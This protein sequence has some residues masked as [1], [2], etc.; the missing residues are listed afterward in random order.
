MTEI[1]A[2]GPPKAIGKVSRVL[3]NPVFW[4]VFLGCTPLLVLRILPALRLL[5]PCDFTLYWAAGRLFL[6]GQNPYSASAMLAVENSL[7]LPYVHP[8]M[9]APPWVL[10]FASV[11]AVIPYREA[12]FGW[13]ALSVVLDCVSALALWSYFGGERK[14][15][16]MALAIVATFLPMATA[17]YIG[18]ITPLI[19][20]SLLAFLLLLRRGRYYWAGVALIGLG[21]KPHL[22]YLVHLA[23]LLWV[24]QQ[25]RWIVLAGAATAYW[26]AIVPI[27]LF[28]P[29]TH[30]YF[31][32]A[33]GP[34]VQ[35]LTGTGGLLRS[36]FG[37][38]RTWLQFLPSGIGVVWFVLYW[39]RNRKQWDWAAH[40]PLLLLISLC[41]APYFWYHDFILVLPAIIF[42]AAERVERVPFLMPA[43]LLVQ[44]AILLC[45]SISQA[46][47]ATAGCLWIGFYFYARSLQV[48]KELPP[49]PASKIAGA[50]N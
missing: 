16:W 11:A 36:V 14:R 13:L 44:C 41:S 32:S 21:L 9:L 5:G 23:I 18:Q 26:V 35:V 38:Q 2:T 43:W 29:Y 45:A 22:L 12:R 33:L 30:N 15:A 47:E 42:I 31:R 20:A 4:I 7:G 40:L 49:L 10:P 48:G 25:R 24:V 8:L 6:S 46:L 39:R 3:R 19:L 27:L 28:N 34:A 37:V 1:S 17:E 50:V